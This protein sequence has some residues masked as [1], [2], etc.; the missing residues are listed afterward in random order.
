MTRRK[1]ILLAILGAFV[2]LIGLL[3]I[4]AILPRA[5]FSAQLPTPVPP[6]TEVVLVA[7][8]DLPIRAV[9]RPQDLAQI[10][11]PLELAPL[12]AMT[13]VEAAVGRMTKVPMVAGELVLAHH[14]ADPTNLSQD[15]AFVL[16]DDQVLMAF[17]ATDLM[18]QINLLQRGD[19]VDVLASIEQPILPGAAGLTSLTSEKDEKKDMLFT[20][21]A[22]Q[23]VEVSAMVVEVIPSRRTG[24]TTA[25][26][27]SSTLANSSATPQPT[28]TPDLSE[29]E[30]KAIL[31]ALSPQDALVLKHIKDAGGIIDIVLRAPTST[32]RFVLDPVMAE[33]LRDRYELVISR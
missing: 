27:S 16:A 26:A 3:L 24:A 6:R 4:G 29:I 1:G 12:N 13:E 5:T 11:V 15:M 32:A 8:H 21:T 22:L 31:L 2:I 30:P 19:L 28:P 20:F 25:S 10:Q 18:S 23:Q 14:L 7:T 17:P 9:L 33:Y